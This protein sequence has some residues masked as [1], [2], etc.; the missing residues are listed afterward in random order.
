MILQKFKPIKIDIFYECFLKVYKYILKDLK[1]YTYVLFIIL[2]MCVIYLILTKIINIY[3]RPVQI[4]KQIPIKVVIYNILTKDYYASKD[5]QDFLQIR[6]PKQIW[7]KIVEYNEEIKNN[8]NTIIK[9]ENKNI[10]TYIKELDITVQITKNNSY[11]IIHLNQHFTLESL[12][13]KI[14]N[15]IYIYSEKNNMLI[16]HNDAFDRVCEFNNY[17]NFF[18][19]SHQNNKTFVLKNHLYK[20]SICK[21]NHQSL[22]IL[23]NIDEFKN[24]F[25]LQDILNI[26]TETFNFLDKGVLIIN[27]KGNILFINDILSKICLIKSLKNNFEEF[28]S[29]FTKNLLLSEDTYRFTKKYINDVISGSQNTTF[30]FQN[31]NGNRIKQKVFYLNNRYIIS[32]FQDITNEFF[33]EQK[34]TK[35]IKYYDFFTN[36]TDEILLIFDNKKQFV[37]GN[38]SSNFIPK[39]YLKNSN[40]FYNTLI[41]QNNNKYKFNF[42]N[43]ENEFNLIKEIINEEECYL[44][45]KVDNKINIDKNNVYFTKIFH[46][47]DLQ[48]KYLQNLK[49]QI[50]NNEEH[51]ER[52]SI[53]ERSITKSHLNLMLYIDNYMDEINCPLI[54]SDVVLFIRNFFENINNIYNIQHFNISFNTISYI[55]N[56]NL[57]ILTRILYYLTE[58]T[59]NFVNTERQI[60]IDTKDNELIISII[61]N[62]KFDINNNYNNRIIFVINKLLNNIKMKM[63]IEEYENNFI[64]KITE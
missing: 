43:T 12:I 9:D 8:Y 37:Y 52:L 2:F 41:K 45:K 1:I 59:Y 50:T 7:N 13:E 36:Y 51:I 55:I 16:Y 40:I 31:I 5:L 62:S 14:N 4:V 29:D 34:K 32:I 61:I 25:H 58:L 49:K 33:S 3:H 48:K 18:Q 56:I 60:I 24:F 20:Q 44:I 35:Q 39:E 46:E 15:P 27:K 63:T 54:K 64:L 53:I 19:T 11:I 42:L 10:I 38:N 23:T 26:Q 21:I 47:I 28:C 22:G 17:H 57:E 6:D 30:T